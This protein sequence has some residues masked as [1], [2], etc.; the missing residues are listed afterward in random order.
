MQRRKVAKQVGFNGAESFSDIMAKIWS[1][2][3]T[4]VCLKKHSRHF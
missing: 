2:E 3:R 4:T 1:P